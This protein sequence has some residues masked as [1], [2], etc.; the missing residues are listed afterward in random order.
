MA[1]LCMNCK[2][3][4]CDDCS[5]AA[6]YLCLLESLK[7]LLVMASSQLYNTITTSSRGCH[8]MLEAIMDLGAPA[9]VPLVTTLLMLVAT[10]PAAPASLQLYTPHS[11]DEYSVIR[12]VR[13]AAGESDRGAAIIISKGY[14]SVVYG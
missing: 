6:G 9:A 8:P 7:L 4:A 3:C 2:H 13:S 10:P 12:L 1:H 5:D 11:K 14:S